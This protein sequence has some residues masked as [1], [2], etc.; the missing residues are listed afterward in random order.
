MKK[1][2]YLLSCFVL[3]SSLIPA[4]SVQ[5]GTRYEVGLNTS[6]TL[7]WMRPGELH[8]RLDTIK[9]LGTTWI[10]VDFNWHLIQPDGPTEYHW[11]MY[12]KV[13]KEATREHLKILAVIGYTPAWA[14]EPR[15]AA[16][17]KNEELARKCNPRSSQEFG[18]FA[19]AAA[20]RYSTQNV[21]GWEIWNEINRTAYWKSIQPNG[22]LFVSP[23]SYAR[24]ANAAAAQIRK[25]TD[26]AVITGG[27]SPLFEPSK[28]TGMRQS[29][30]L[31]QLLP[32]LDIKLFH[33]I[34]IHPY[35]WPARPTKKA[36]YNAF[37]TVNNGK[38]AYNL[39]TIMH[40]CGW[41]RKQIWGTEYGASTKGI[42]KVTRPTRHNRPDHV[43]EY[44]QARI[45][46]QGIV[47][48]YKKPNVGPLFVHSDSDRW[49]KT[50]KNEGGFG[51]R[52]SDNSQKPSYSAFQS[53]IRYVQGLA[54]SR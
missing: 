47:S 5:A 32:L 28:T 15:C 23:R 51:L 39:R 20:R 27:L 43:S 11:Q 4:P 14:R 44:E 50:Q 24:F 33:G 36:V 2:F 25:Y 41:E 53:A 34:A 6:A 29:D 18:R 22:T 48:W 37:Y 16:L 30:Y 46:E 8:Q 9:R 54:R 12:D 17:V 3:L 1:I 40:L 38:P 45:V 35:S 7:L 49:L 52:R 31:K 19:G 21:R 10:R 13:V 42:R 26:G